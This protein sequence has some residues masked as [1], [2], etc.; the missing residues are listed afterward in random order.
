MCNCKPDW[1][2]P[3]AIYD[4]QKRI[5]LPT[6]YTYCQNC[7]EYSDNQGR[8]VIQP[9]KRCPGFT[10]HNI[11]SLCYECGQDERGSKHRTLGLQE[12]E[13]AR[14]SKGMPREAAFVRHWLRRVE[15]MQR[16]RR[17]ETIPEADYQSEYQPQSQTT[18]L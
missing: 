3:F 1:R 5:D 13:A 17:G 2:K 6:L 4:P 7:G 15:L 12:L 10:G 18:L 9:S 14:E 8:C 16:I 11:G